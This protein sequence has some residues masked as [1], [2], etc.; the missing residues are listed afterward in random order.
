MSDDAYCNI[1][2][3]EMKSEH[4]NKIYYDVFGVQGTSSLR[5]FCLHVREKCSITC[6][7]LLLCVNAFK[8]WRCT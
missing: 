5:M 3:N 4:L 7:L 1:I 8:P 6:C 2:P